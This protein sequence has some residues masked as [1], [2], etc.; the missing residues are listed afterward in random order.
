MHYAQRRASLAA[1]D[2]VDVVVLVPGANLK[3]F[4]G[5]DYHLSERPLLALIRGEELMFISPELE[6]PTINARLGW[7]SRM[8]TWSDADGYDGAFSAALDELGLRGKVLG[9]DDNTMRVFEWLAFQNADPTIQLRKLGKKL[10]EVRAIKTE[11][12]IGAMRT[13]VAHSEAAL[14]NLL[15]WIEPGMTEREIAAK[16]NE[17]LLAGGCDSLSFPAL[18]QTGPNSALPHGSV[19]DRALQEGE[20]LLIDFGGMVDS[21]PA[22]ITRTFC[23]GTPSEEM[24]RIYD[25]VLRANRAAVAAA[26]PGIACGDVD[27]AARDVIAAA[28]YGEYFIHRTG[29]GLGLEVHELPQ[30]AQDVEDLLKPGMVFTIEPGIYVPGLGGVRIEENIVITEHGAEELTRFRRDLRVR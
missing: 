21:Y 17:D 26:G 18:V 14:N 16:L 8:F 15:H 19:T 6:V 22:D 12:E 27:R 10:L 4:T 13:A 25:T 23:I 30:I 28:G 5:L 24:Q 9:V 7:E 2:H 11:E 1:F 29:H 20:F 3:Y